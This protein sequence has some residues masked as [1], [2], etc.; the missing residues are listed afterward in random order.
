MCNEEFWGCAVGFGSVQEH[1][2]LGTA[3]DKEITAG[4]PD[5]SAPR[6]HLCSVQGHF[7]GMLRAGAG[8]HITTSLVPTW[9]R[10]PR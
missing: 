8:R 10:C 3:A 6:C 2:A 5:T 1:P 9:P 7:V 4:L